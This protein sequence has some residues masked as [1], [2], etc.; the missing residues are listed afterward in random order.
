MYAVIP[1]KHLKKKKKHLEKVLQ[2]PFF[3]KVI[4]DSLAIR[5]QKKQQ[6]PKPPVYQ[7]VFQV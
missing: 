2:K 1:L 5:E 4:H 7:A 6:P 3:C